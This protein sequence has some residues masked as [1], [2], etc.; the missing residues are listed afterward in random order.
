MRSTFSLFLCTFLGATALL[1]GLDDAAVIMKTANLMD[2]LHSIIDS[3]DQWPTFNEQRAFIEHECISGSCEKIQECVH[4]CRLIFDCCSHK[5]KN[6]D[7]REALEQNLL[8]LENTCNPTTLRIFPLPALDLDSGVIAINGSNFVITG[9]SVVSGDE[10]IGGSLTVTSTASMAGNVGIGGA[11]STSTDKL[12][13]TG[14]SR[15]TGNETIGGTLT[16]GGASTFNGSA[17]LNSPITV[18]STA[19]F[20]NTLTAQSTLTVASSTTLT[21]NVGIGGAPGAAKLL[22]T[23][24]TQT[25]G[26]ETVGGTLAVTGASTLT[27]NVSVGGNL[28]VGGTTDFNGNLTFQPGKTELN[29]VGSYPDSALRI[30]AG[31]VNTSNAAKTGGG[32][33][34][35]RNK[36]GDVTITFTQA[37]TDAPVVTATAVDSNNAARI[38]APVSA[39]AIR[40]DRKND[41]LLH[42]IAIGPS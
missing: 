9:N 27:G 42:F 34:V 7:D 17:T 30:V 3:H 1:Q 41:G 26:N 25:T 23:G 13:V 40:L 39:S 10:L 2:I 18:N 33:T 35:V 24:N 14:N 28:T 38:I 19:L 6:S 12:L 16:V 37:F 29:I 32:F 5:I 15:V 11:A 20:N 8:A 21:G 36:A 22:V 4:H 31:T